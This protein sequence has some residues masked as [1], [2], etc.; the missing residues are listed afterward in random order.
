VLAVP[1]LAAGIAQLRA[2][3]GADP[4]PG[5]RHAGLGTWNAVLP[6]ALSPALGAGP[7]YLELIAADPLSAPPS[8]PRPFGLDS[9][10]RPRLVGWAVRTDA[11][12]AAVRAARENG[13]DAGAVVA[14]ERETPDGA[15]LRW[16]LSALPRPAADGL[17]PFL[18]DW[19]D[20][21]QPSRAAPALCRLEAFCGLHPEP[22][23]VT[24]TLAAIGASL[25]LEHAPR[26]GLRAT[27]AGPLGRIV[28]G[29][30][31]EPG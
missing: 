11:I 26:A 10:R 19:G 22:A 23:R 21:P 18:I 14:V 9:L 8:R 28:L 3:L 7:A 5:G 4:L 24:A 2:R 6:L 13:F 12:D 30:E 1:D 20:A 16:R 15:R 27:I 29:D 31:P 25:A 17:A